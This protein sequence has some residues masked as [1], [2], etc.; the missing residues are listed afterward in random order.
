VLP[1]G[2]WWVAGILFVSMLGVPALRVLLDVLVLRQTP[3]QERGR[4]IAAVMVLL[5]LGTPVGVAGAGLLLQYLSATTTMLVLAVVL[6]VAVAVFA[7]RRELL[8]A[9]W[10]ARSARPEAQG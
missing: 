6:A 4:V 7:T 2:P 5:G 9:R 8:Q 3:D 10:P 1:F